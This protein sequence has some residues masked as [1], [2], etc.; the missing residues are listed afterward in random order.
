M[1]PQFKAFSKIPRLSREIICTEK[2]DGTN[3]LI[4]IDLDMNIFAGSHKVWLWGSMQDEVHNDNHGFA[5]WVKNNQDD[6]RKLGPGYHY[7]EWWGQGIQRKYGLTEKRF[8]L[9]NTTRWMD[10]P[11]KPDCCSIVPLLYTGPFDMHKIDIVLELLT[12]EGSV[13]APGFKPAEGIVLYH[14]ASRQLFKK[15]LVGDEKGKSQ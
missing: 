3:G 10:N 13:A 12:Y 8:S 11:Y 6:L 9:F 2:I 15:T 14:T 1:F 4:Y 5:Q 7:G